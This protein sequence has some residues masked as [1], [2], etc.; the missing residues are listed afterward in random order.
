MTAAY[1][2][3]RQ[4][5]VL[6]LR[7]TTASPRMG[8]LTEPEQKV[9]DVLHELHQSKYP[10]RS[11]VVGKTGAILESTAFLGPILNIS[12][13]PSTGANLLT[14][15]SE[16]KSFELH[17]TLNKVSKIVFVT[18]ETPDKVMRLVRLL[19]AEGESIAASFLPLLAKTKRPDHGLTV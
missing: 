7:M 5:Y 15:A 18:R 11:V 12:Q 3:S 10:F 4:F 13:Q 9:Y 19:N 17:L 14:L 1:S 16:D 8:E 2:R 6:P